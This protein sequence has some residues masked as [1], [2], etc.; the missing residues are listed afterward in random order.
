M[1]FQYGLNIIY[2]ILISSTKV[3]SFINIFEEQLISSG[4]CGKHSTE[5][6]LMYRNGNLVKGDTF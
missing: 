1:F 5:W 2:K 6:M 4:I 3:G